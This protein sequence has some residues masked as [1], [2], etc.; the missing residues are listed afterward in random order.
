MSLADY[1]PQ[2]ETITSRN[3]KLTVSVRG[4]ALEDIVTLFQKNLD[5]I[6]KLFDIYAKSD[7]MTEQVG[8]SVQIATRLISEAPDVA[9]RII[10]LACDEPEA[11]DK[12][13]S[14]T[15]PLQIKII[16]KIIEL[17]FDEA[18]GARNFLLSLRQTVGG[19]LPGLRASNT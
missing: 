13:K 4:L 9:S 7:V 19:F 12:A 14:L 10:A 11:L 6:N 2:R 16:Q 1:Q 5:D 18:G 3:G 8:E 17:T 15:V